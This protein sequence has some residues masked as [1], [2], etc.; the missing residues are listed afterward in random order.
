MQQLNFPAC[1]VQLKNR[2]NKPYIFDQIRKKWVLCTPEEWVRI[3]CLNYLTQTLG[4]PASWI[5]VENEIKLYNTRKRF[6]IM[7]MNPIEGNFILVECKAPNIPLDQHVFDQIARYNLQVKSRF[8][9]LTN[10]LNHYFCAMDYENQHYQF[11]KE[12]PK[13]KSN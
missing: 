8:M 6:D 3:H 4:Y 9:M 12:L 7:V 1:E 11:I 13:Y 5:K 2:E 10:G